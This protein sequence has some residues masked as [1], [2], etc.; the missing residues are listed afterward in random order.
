VVEAVLYVAGTGDTIAEAS[1]FSP[2]Y[3]C[4]ATATTAS[5]VRL[6]PKAVL[7][8]EFERNPA[9]AQ[10]FMAMLG[11]QVMRLRTRLEQRSIRSARDRVRHYLAVNT[12]ADGQTVVLAG[13]LK[14]LTDQSVAGYRQDTS[15]RVG[16]DPAL[17]AGHSLRAG[18]LTS[19][20]K[21]GASI[22]KMDGNVRI[23]PVTL[24]S[25]GQGFNAPRGPYGC[26]PQ[27]AIGKYEPC[28]RYSR[29]RRCSSHA[30]SISRSI[31]TAYIDGE[32]APSSYRARSVASCDRSCAA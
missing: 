3:Q 29:A 5:I 7:L 12:S 23:M 27:P 17:F 16:L 21:R 24:A 10:A 15:E 13:T 20:A 4:D 31:I 8:A 22:F 1:L 2:T 6:Y 9:A 11:H 26:G 19:A 32:T 30:I 18:F 28:F 25:P 14:E